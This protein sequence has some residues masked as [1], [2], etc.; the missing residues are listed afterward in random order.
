MVNKELVLN[1]LVLFSSALISI[2]VPL[3]L[4]ITVAIGLV[5]ESQIDFINAIFLIISAIASIIWAIL[6]DRY[7]RKRLLIIGT[8]IWSVFSF[9]TIFA[10]DFNSLFLFQII[11]AIGFGSALPLTF[12]LLIDIVKVEKRATAFGRLSAIYVLGNGIGLVLASLSEIETWYIPFIVVSLSGFICIV[13]LIMMKGLN[14]KNRQNLSEIGDDSIG[15]SYKMDWKD[16]KE[17]WNRPSILL[18]IIF[19]FTMF[20]GI[21]AFA[22][23]FTNMLENDYLYIFTGFESIIAT[24]LMIL[25]YGSQMI[26]GPLIGN[27][28]DKKYVKNKNM[29]MKLVLYCLVIG[30]VIDMIAYS[31]IFNPTNI[32]FLVIF[33]IFLFIG[34]FLFGGI[35]PLTQATLG[36]LSPPQIRSTVYSLNFIAY[37]F[38]RSISMILFGFLYLFFGSSYRLSFL[39]LSTIS[40]ICSVFVLIILKTLSKDILK[41]SKNED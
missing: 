19:N 41:E 37:I 12:S 7:S 3:R 5:N 23:Q 31:L 36:D 32:I 1:I 28:G 17:I 8:S 33:L 27:L 16:L 4:E 34:T 11:T 22:P 13:F 38:G 29:R 20:I 14:I 21:G 10:Y 9:I 35:D 15:L 25:V 6:G 2:I 30:S 18:I 40:L 24:I 26:S 39:V